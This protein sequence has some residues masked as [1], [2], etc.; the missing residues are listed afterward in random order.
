[1]NS[2]NSV[3]LTET[4]QSISLSQQQQPQH[5]QL[6]VSVV[7]P[8]HNNSIHSQHSCQCRDIVLLPEKDT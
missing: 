3:D 2:S 7:V 4:I 1:M 8:F 6:M 5:Q